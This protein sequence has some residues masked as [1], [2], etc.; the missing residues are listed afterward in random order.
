M[1]QTPTAELRPLSLSFTSRSPASRSVATREWVTSSVSLITKIVLNTLATLTTIGISLAVVLAG[2]VA[3][4]EESLSIS[5][6]PS[7]DGRIDT[8]RSR[9]SYRVD[10]GQAVADQYFVQNTGTVA[11]K[12]TIYATDAFN[13]EDGG[14]ALLD[15][16][17]TPSDVG[18]WVL[19]DGGV[20]R[21]DLTLA[22]GES[23]VVGFTMTVPAEATPGDHAGGIVV[24]AQSDGEGQVVLDRRIATRLYARV[25]G[26][27]FPLL[28]ISSIDAKYTGDF[29]NPFGGTATITTTL[30]NTGNVSLG[31]SVVAGVNGVFGI[32]LT[33]F[34]RLEVP[35]LLPGTTRTYSFEVTG[36]GAWIYLNPYISLLGTIDE[37][38]IVPGPMPVMARSVSLFV[39]PWHFLIALIV[40]GAVIIGMRARARS[41]EDRAAEWIAYAAAQSAQQ[42]GD[43]K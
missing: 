14:F 31:A 37:D 24:S 4:A 10:P 39:V 23:R 43:K 2:S 29:F 16:S 34:V 7:A 6:A 25:K 17:E 26:D 19:F 1:S 13:S 18:S 28:A 22:P 20:S 32:P 33:Q 21:V 9:F 35:E 5:A 30:S 40:V 38:A 3:F 42:K 36:V 11:Q 8:S 15:T 41:N 12:V 27:L